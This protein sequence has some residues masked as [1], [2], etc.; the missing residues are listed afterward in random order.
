LRFLN[1][2]ITYI[3]SMSEEVE[4]PPEMVEK[5]EEQLLEEQKQRE[6]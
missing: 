3:E 1:I 6:E 2:F 4:N 5:T